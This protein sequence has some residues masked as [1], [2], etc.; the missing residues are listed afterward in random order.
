MLFRNLEYDWQDM[1]RRTFLKTSGAGAC[2][3]AAPGLRGAEPNSTADEAELLSRAKEQIEK[4]RKGDGVIVVRDASGKPI[5]NAILKLEQTRHQFLFGCNF[6]MFGRIRDPEREE[7][8]RRRFASL[9]NYATLGFYWPYYEPER[10]KP[11]YDYT[12]KVTAWCREHGITCKGHPLVWDYADP[13]W[14]PQDFAEIRA[15]S[16]ARVREIVERFHGRIDI[17]DVVNEPTHLGRF[18]TRTGERAMAMGAVP[19]TAEALKIARAANPRALLLVN[20][21]RT[22]PP[23]QQILEE[24]REDGKLLFDAIGIQSHMHGG[25]WPLRKI[26]DVCSGPRA[27]AKRRRPSTCRSFTRCCSRTR[28]WRR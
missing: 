11:I 25:G 3:L 26:W 10:G 27:E 9:L 13:K 23:F 2:W 1:N 28:R 15:L 21:Y 4:H 20:D 14:L 16:N 6:F 19:Y 22:D 7:E 18:K 24:L 8:Y 12:D 5:A 17:W